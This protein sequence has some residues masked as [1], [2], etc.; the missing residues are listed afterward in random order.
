L[1]IH[2]KIVSVSELKKSESRFDRDHI[3]LTESRIF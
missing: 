2:K 3:C 1:K